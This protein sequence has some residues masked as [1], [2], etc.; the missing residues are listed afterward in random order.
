MGHDKDICSF[1]GCRVFYI[2][3]KSLHISEIYGNL[4]NAKA[5]ECALQTFRF[6]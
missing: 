6:A 1:P 5:D 2:L 4:R 3:I